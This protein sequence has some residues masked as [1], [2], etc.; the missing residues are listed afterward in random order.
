M[1]NAVIWSW[2][3]CFSREKRTR[4]AQKQNDNNSTSLMLVV[5]V[6]IFLIVNLPQVS[7]A[8][9]VF[10]KKKSYNEYYILGR[11]FRYW[12]WERVWKSDE[13]EGLKMNEECSPKRRIW[14][15]TKSLLARRVLLY[16]FEVV[17]ELPIENLFSHSQEPFQAEGSLYKKQNLDQLIVPGNVHGGSMCVRNV[18]SEM[19]PLR[20]HLSSSFPARK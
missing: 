2:K 14:W 7:R 5:I 9:H 15:E 20:R 12:I 17:N 11:K 1:K 3:K 6:T 8:S 19:R 13:D 16:I 4:D 10:S 18:L